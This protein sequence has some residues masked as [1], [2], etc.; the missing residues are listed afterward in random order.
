[1]KRPG[2]L[3][4][5]AVAVVLA[6]IAGAS[7]TA[8][9]PLVSVSFL[10]RFLIMGAAGAYVMYLLFRSR[11]RTGRIA[12]M[13]LWGISA[14]GIWFFAPSFAWYVIA[15]AGLIWLV[16]A[17]YFYTGLWPA[18]LDLGIGALGVIAAV[19]TAKHTGSLS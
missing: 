16:R 2:F 19:A 6:T 18:L 14:I 4:G 17:P 12:T 13:A 3:E 5:V 9:T 10:V 11:I 7:L 1:M 8:L 15:H